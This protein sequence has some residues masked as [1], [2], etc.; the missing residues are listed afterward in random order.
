V[1]AGVVAIGAVIMA[2]VLGFQ[3]GETVLDVTAVCV[4]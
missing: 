1:T 4:K 3:V 2:G